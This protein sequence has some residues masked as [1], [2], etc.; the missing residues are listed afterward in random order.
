M[1]QLVLGNVAVDKRI[2]GDGGEAKQEQEP[3]PQGGERD[4]QKES[5]VLAHELAHAKNIPQGRRS[6]A[7]GPPAN[8]GWDLDRLTV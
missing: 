4:P 5:E 1:L 8:T 2:G 7:G 6:F 3:Q